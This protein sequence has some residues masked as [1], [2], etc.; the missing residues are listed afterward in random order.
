MFLLFSCFS[1]QWRRPWGKRASVTACQE[2][3]ASRLAGCSWP[4]LERWATTWRWNTSGQW[5][6]NWTKNPQR[7][8]TAQSTGGSLR[9]LYGASPRLSS[10]TWRIPPITASRTKAWECRAPRDA[11]ARRGIRTSPRRRRKAAGVCA[12]NAASEWCKSALKWWAA[13]TANF[14]GAARSGAKNACKWSQSI[15][16]RAEKGERDTIIKRSAGTVRKGT[17]PHLFYKLNARVLAWWIYIKCYFLSNKSKTFCCT[18]IF[19]LK[20]FLIPNQATF[21]K[22]KQNRTRGTPYCEFKSCL[23]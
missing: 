14:T 20:L 18:F 1:R 22:K 5:S 13:A 7:R 8:G 9:T 19:W 4:T 2:A 3:A 11:S 16:A 10:F 17:E 21:L 6:W 15:T 23:V 12:T